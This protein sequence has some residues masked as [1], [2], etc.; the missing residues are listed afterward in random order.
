MYTFQKAI[1]PRY[2]TWGKLFNQDVYKYNKEK[3]IKLKKKRF[4]KI[5]DFTVATE[6]RVI[7]HKICNTGNCDWSQ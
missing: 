1:N 3:E 7:D 4:V 6:T 5:T 2:H